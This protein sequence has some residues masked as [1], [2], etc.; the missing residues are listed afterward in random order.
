M[1]F[2]IGLGLFLIMVDAVLRLALWLGENYYYP[3]FGFVYIGL[4]SVAFGLMLR[5]FLIP[6]LFRITIYVLISLSILYPFSKFMMH[7]SDSYMYHLAGALGLWG[8]STGIVILV[9]SPKT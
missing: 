9:L 4:L 3:D 8:L 5:S 1:N 7:L 6:T 2:A